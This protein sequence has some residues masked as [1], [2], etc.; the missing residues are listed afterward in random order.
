MKSSDKKRQPLVTKAKA[1]D[2]LNLNRFTIK[3]RYTAEIDVMDGI[4]P[5]VTEREKN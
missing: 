2:E 3:Y 1:P 5:Y 4:N